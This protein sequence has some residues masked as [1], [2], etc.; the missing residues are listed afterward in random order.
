MTRKTLIA[1]AM[2]GAVIASV[3]IVAP[4]RALAAERVAGMTV[5][6]SDE[7][8]AHSVALSIDKSLVIDL[9]IDVKQMLISNPKIANAVLL[10]NRRAY[11]I[12]IAIGQTNV[13]F[14]DTNSRQIEALDITVH[15]YL[16]PAALPRD[17]Q[18]VVIIFRGPTTWSSL[19]CAAAGSLIEG[20]ACYPRGEEPPATLDSLPKGSSVTMPVGK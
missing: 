4:D 10:T 15:N 17:R 2:V 14:F 12:G 8:A 3:G 1:S 7:V 20:E 16:V 18:N 5:T 11:I 6:S 19:N 13:F 9:P